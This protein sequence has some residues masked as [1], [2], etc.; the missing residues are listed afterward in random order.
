MKKSQRKISFRF[1]NKSKDLVVQQLGKAGLNTLGIFKPLSTQLAR[2]NHVHTGE[3]V[4][5]FKLLND[6]FNP[7][8]V[9]AAVLDRVESHGDVEGMLED[10]G[11]SLWDHYINYWAILG[12]PVNAIFKST[13]GCFVCAWLTGDEYLAPFLDS[14]YYLLRNSD[15]LRE[16]DDVLSHWLLHG[17]SDG[18]SPSLPL[19]MSG[20]RS[21]DLTFQYDNCAQFLTRSFDIRSTPHLESLM[22]GLYDVRNCGCQASEKGDSCKMTVDRLVWEG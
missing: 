19:V 8:Y 11:S 2:P 13:E 14:S 7:Y 22:H 17:Y 3:I 15:V 16:K 6:L 10:S 20:E 5:S 21:N 18:R 1:K 4:R 12:V 9:K